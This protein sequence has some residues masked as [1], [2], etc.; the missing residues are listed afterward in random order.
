[1]KRA[2]N[3]SEIVLVTTLLNKH[4]QNDFNISLRHARMAAAPAS[5]EGSFYH[6]QGIPFST[7]NYSKKGSSSLY[8][9]Q[10]IKLRTIIKPGPR[11]PVARIYHYVNVNLKLLNLVH[12][13]PSI[14]K[15]L[16]YAYWLGS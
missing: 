15:D 6:G 11:T 14:P 4:I 3:V 5:D 8:M 13:L 9:T 12:A 10:Y 2:T 16:R 7:L 1:M